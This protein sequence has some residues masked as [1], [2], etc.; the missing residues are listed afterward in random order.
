MTESFSDNHTLIILTNLYVEF[1]KELLKRSIQD[2]NVMEWSHLCP[3][4]WVCH[5]D[6]HYAPNILLVALWTN[7]N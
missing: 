5:Q 6:H 2:L 7:I 1:L 4:C 3:L